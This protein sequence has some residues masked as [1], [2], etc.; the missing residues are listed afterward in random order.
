MCWTHTGCIIEWTA[1]VTGMSTEGPALNTSPPKG[2]Q[3]EVHSNHTVNS[4]LAAPHLD[5]GCPIRG[6]D[7]NLDQSQ[8]RIW[9]LTRRLDWVKFERKTT[10]TEVV[11]FLPHFKKISRSVPSWSSHG[12][13]DV[14]E[15]NARISVRSRFVSVCLCASRRAVPREEPGLQSDVRP[16]GVSEL[17]QSLHLQV[18]FV[19]HPRVVASA[20]TWCLC[21]NKSPRVVA[22]LV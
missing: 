17:L 18:S 20:H 13:A 14:G 16:G 6:S 7:Q 4:P 15:E 10:R 21:R 11:F 8:V 2:K 9:L 1:A 12:C 3:T 19:F 5:P 22:T